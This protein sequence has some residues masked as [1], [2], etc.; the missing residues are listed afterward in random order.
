MKIRVTKSEDNHWYKVGEEYEVADKPVHRHGN[1][2]YPLVDDFNV[3]I[4][5]GDFE[6]VDEQPKVLY[7]RCIDAGFSK[8]IKGLIYTVQD[9]YVVGYGTI[10]RLREVHGDWDN[11]RF[12]VVKEEPVANNL[13]PQVYVPNPEEEKIIIDAHY[14]FNYVITEN[15]RK[16]GVIKVDPYFVAK[17]YNLGAKDPS[18]VIWHIFKTCARFGEKNDKAREITAIYKSIKRL[19]ELEGVKLD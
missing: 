15:D 18:G 2:Y 19:A 8:L 9:S 13:G 17:Q 1:Y 14:S 10:Y 7:V 5:I 16:K 3:G 12:E 11:S 4:G 6:V